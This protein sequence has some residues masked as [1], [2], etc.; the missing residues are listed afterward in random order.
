MESADV[1]E[2]HMVRPVML[3]TIATRPATM[4]PT[5]TIHANHGSPAIM[6]SS[7]LEGFQ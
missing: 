4:M 5:I 6:F 7:G 2:D 3:P 1:L